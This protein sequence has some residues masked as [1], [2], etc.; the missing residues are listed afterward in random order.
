M[1]PKRLLA[2]TI[3]AA[4]AVLQPCV[5]R[6]QMWQPTN[7]LYGGG[8]SSVVENRGVLFGEFGSYG[9][10][11]STDE[12]VTWSPA[13][14][15]LPPSVGNLVSDGTHVFLGSEYQIYMWSD[16][17]MSWVARTPF[18]LSIDVAPIGAYKNNLYG[19]ADGVYRS[20]DTG[21]TWTQIDTG[22][23]DN[24][25]VTSFAV[26]DSFIFIV[27][28]SGESFRS[29]DNGDHWTELDTGNTGFQVFSFVTMGKDLFA[30]CYQGMLYSTDYGA[31]WASCDS[32]LPVQNISVMA[33]LGST[34]IV[35]ASPGYTFRTTVE[36]VGKCNPSG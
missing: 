3:F 9:I 22:L 24:T 8:F 14:Q 11:R 2:L 6:A 23:T 35:S 27:T 34:I 5:L 7:G 33:V 31:T 13:N 26:V 15:N 17:S 29:S 16:D 12:G 30:G 1:L 20:R 21:L 32:G 19:C 25:N 36:H 10:F 28:L 4:L 18:G